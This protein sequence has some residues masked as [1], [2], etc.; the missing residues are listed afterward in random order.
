MGEMV[1]ERDNRTLQSGSSK[2]KR[3]MRDAKQRGNEESIFWTW[4]RAEREYELYIRYKHKE[5]S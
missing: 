4:Q 2:V 5:Y 1:E 3:G